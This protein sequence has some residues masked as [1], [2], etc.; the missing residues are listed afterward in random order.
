MSSKR[1]S[2]KKG[3]H[4]TG[5]E[6]ASL[7]LHVKRLIHS[8][9]CITLTEG[10]HKYNL[11]KISVNQ[12]RAQRVNFDGYGG[13]DCMLYRQP[14]FPL[15]VLPVLNEQR[16]LQAIGVSFQ[17]HSNEKALKCKPRPLLHHR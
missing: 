5:I 6:S 3:V 1:K 16:M 17:L 10:A 7:T 11:H 9:T 2:K 14:S 8:A 15:H 4:C 13:Y 12:Q